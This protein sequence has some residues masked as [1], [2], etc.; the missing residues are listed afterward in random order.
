VEGKNQGFKRP[1]R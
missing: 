1:E